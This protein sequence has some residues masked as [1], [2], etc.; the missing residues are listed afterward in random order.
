MPWL[1]LVFM[2]LIGMVMFN[3]GA[4][5]LLSSRWL[6]V[7]LLIMVAVPAAMGQGSLAI[8]LVTGGALWAGTILL[9]LVQ[10]QRNVVIPRRQIWWSVVVGLVA[11]LAV[12]GTAL[13]GRVSCI[14]SWAVLLLGVVSYLLRPRTGERLVWWRWLTGLALCVGGGAI[15]VWAMPTVGAVCGWSPMLVGTLL[16]P[17]CLISTTFGLWRKRTNTPAVVLTNAVGGMVTG[18]ITVGWGLLGVI[19]GVWTVGATT[20]LL[21]L[22]CLA[23]TLLL[24]V[25]P[26]LWRQKSNRWLGALLA[27]IYAGYL[28][29]LWL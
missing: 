4:F 9:A 7:P 11:L 2:G 5:F 23:L 17:C 26:L 25:T 22:P 10:W 12:V 28:L 24:G 6:G 8:G 20:R 13:N 1:W 19:G 21:T 27:V 29:L 16:A 3:Y 15:T 18:L 14:E